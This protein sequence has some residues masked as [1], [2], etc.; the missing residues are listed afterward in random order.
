MRAIIIAAGSNTKIVTITDKMPACMLPLVDKPFVQHL[1]EFLIVKG[2]TS[3]DFVLSE[4]PE[5][6]EALLGD[7]TRWGGKFSF[8]PV[9]DADQPWKAVRLLCSPSDEKVLIADA[10]YLPPV[11][12]E[13]IASPGDKP[14]LWMD[15]GMSIGT[16][17]DWSGWA[18]CS[19]ASLSAIADSS[20]RDDV[21]NHLLTVGGIPTPCAKV[22]TVSSFDRLIEAQKFVIEGWQEELVITGSRKNADIVIGRG[23]RVHQSASL[24][25]PL[26]VGE[27]S[28]V[29]AGVE[30]EPGTVIARDCVIDTGCHIKDSIILPGTYVGKELDIVGCLADHGVL[31]NARLSTEIKIPDNFLLGRITPG[32]ASSRPATFASQVGAFVLLLLLWPLLVISI[33]FRATAG[34]GD[35]LYRKRMVQLPTG[36]DKDSWKYFDRFYVG[37]PT[38][39]LNDN[40][41]Q[42]LRADLPGLINVLRG[43]MYFVG[44]PGR[45]MDEI[46][47]LEP[48]WRE[49]YLGSKVGLVTEVRV[50][51]GFQPEIEE[52]HASDTFYAVNASQGY[53]MKLLGDFVRKQF[54]TD[55]S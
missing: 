24:T 6:L 23:A 27:F 25:G 33:V 39:M 55:R 18:T 15:G 28:E 29:G 42:F 17:S 21:F 53:D 54:R 45:T 9:R 13:A 40:F 8:H 1:V 44:A 48:E 3:I 26:Y 47:E 7:G 52:Q 12:A 2:I 46:D 51:C 4:F 50:R 41:A 14:I 22:L 16:A 11:P 37:N 10:N 35:A 36:A 32:S 19:S 20:T 43:D 5:Q 49:L 30:L 38:D 31:Y 34:N